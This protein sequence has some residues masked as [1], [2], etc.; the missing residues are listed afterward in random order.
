[1]NDEFSLLKDTVISYNKALVSFYSTLEKMLKEL[2]VLQKEYR[3]NVLKYNQGKEKRFDILNENHT[4]K[5]SEVNDKER[6]FLGEINRYRLILEEGA[7]KFGKITPEISYRIDE[8]K[9][10]ISEFVKFEEQRIN[11][12]HKEKY[13]EFEKQFKLALS[14]LEINHE[15]EVEGILN[16]VRNLLQQEL[17]DFFIEFNKYAPTKDED[18][19]NNEITTFSSNNYTPLVEIGTFKKNI[20]I[21]GI[22]LQK[23]LKV[24]LPFLDCNSLLIIHDNK[25][26]QNVDSIHDTLITRA[27]ISNEVGKVNLTLS[28]LKGL[29]EFFREFIPLSHEFVKIANGKNKLEETLVECESRLQEVSIKYTASSKY[30]DFISLGSYNYDKIK[31]KKFEEIIPH[32]ISVILNLSYDSDEQLIKKLSNLI[33]NGAKNGTQFIL[34]WNIDD[35]TSGNKQLL[36]DI[37]SNN[38]VITIDLV[39]NRS[40]Y[41]DVEH[42]LIPNQI[43]KEKKHDLVDSYNF[44][45]AE[46]A[47]KV[48]KELFI[49][50]MPAKNQ[51]FSRE[52]SEQVSI[53]VG[54]SKQHRGEQNIDIKTSDFQA[55]LMLSGG[56]GS[57]KTNFLKTFITSAALHYS[58]D[59]LEFYLIDLKN[60]IGFDIFRKFQLPHVKMFAM[61]AENELIYNL[62]N[63]L[64]DEMNKRLNLFAENG[65]DDIHK[66]NKAHPNN[67]VKRTILIIDELATA[68]EGDYPLKDEIIDRLSPLARKAR[69]AGI[70]LFFS[71]QNFNRIQGISKINSEIPIRIVLKSS[72]DAANA[73]LDSRNDAMK[74]VKT[75][76]DGVV[77]YQLGVKQDE[78][79]NQLF[80][81][82]LL[83]NDD[84]EKILLEIKEESEKRGYAPNELIVY[85]NFTQAVFEENIDIQAQNRLTI[86]KESIKVPTKYRKIPIWLGEP[87]NIS[88]SHFKINLEKN[89]NENIL[90]TGIDKTVSINAIFNI[91]SSLTYAFASGEIAIRVFS[92][93]NEE[94]ND[95]YSLNKLGKMS[96]EFDYKFLNSE[97]YYEEFEK[98]NNELKL[99]KNENNKQ[100]KRIFA[101]FIGLEKAQHFFNQGSFSL[102]DNGEDLKILLESGNAQNIH[103]VC[104][105][106]QPSIL[107]K[108]LKSGAINYFKHRIVFHLGSSDESSTA[109]DHK[110]AASLYKQDEPY[111]K[112]RAIYYD[113]DFEKV[114]YKFKP[115]INLIESDLFYPDNFGK[116]VS[117]NEDI[118]RVITKKKNEELEEKLDV[119]VETETSKQLSSLGELNKQ[120][121]ELDDDDE[122]IDFNNF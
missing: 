42:E 114:F 77:N 86:N 12:D 81:G 106:R 20:E 63:N 8:L 11:K 108:I 43:P 3:G 83:E 18:I 53:P 74:H 26:K 112:Y 82:Y 19:I 101:F 62:I 90:V 50:K 100:T 2:K 22:C 37:I 41:L 61:G 120:L 51:W 68:F 98:L 67:K 105:M 87:T 47:N 5:L 117:N 119:K 65:V 118:I 55:H 40:N 52:S 76:G 28:D 116:Y 25:T 58:P 32:F 4:D 23:E 34:T 71:T 88:K 96:E 72:L 36:D 122:I 48:I 7:T 33:S 49:N 79:D 78:S 1:M 57:G 29:G 44:Q 54:V 85:N 84:L 45:Y 6:K 94:E 60:G 39:G 70:N 92:F 15:I 109:L 13:A 56:T 75:I 121:D 35:E 9:E 115:Y 17:T 46:V 69:A 66:Y 80:K 24:I 89:F 99:R 91:I 107:S 64:N 95:E 110:I 30:S 38:D 93:L 73:L 102:S 97:N 10:V 111:T 16:N 27:L 104:E 14:Q 59:E 21:N 103:A 113:A 31:N